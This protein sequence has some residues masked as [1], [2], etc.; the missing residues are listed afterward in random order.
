MAKGV[1]GIKRHKLPV[2]KEISQGDMIY[3]MV[4]IVNNTVAHI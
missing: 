2:M 4:T 3:N 1:K